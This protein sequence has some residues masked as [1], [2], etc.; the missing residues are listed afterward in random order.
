MHKYNIIHRDLKSENIFKHNEKYKIGDFGFA[1]IITN[2]NDIG[3][4]TTL[5]TLMTMAPEVME[6]RKYGIKVLSRDSLGRHLVARSCLLRDDLWACTILG[7]YCP[8]H[9]LHHQIHIAGSEWLLQVGWGPPQKDA[10]G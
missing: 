5:G 9:E 7:A 1:K 3:D 10:C 6:R 2:L 4:W 8:V